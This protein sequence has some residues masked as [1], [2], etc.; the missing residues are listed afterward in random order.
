MV[1]PQKGSTV[2]EPAK[3]LRLFEAGA[4][5]RH[6]LLLR[7]CQAAAERAPAELV[8]GLPAHVLDEIREWVVRQPTSPDEC[9]VIRSVCAGPGFDAERHFREE[10]RQLYDG[11]WR[12]HRYFAEAEPAAASDRC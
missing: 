7:L 9:R 10:A 8:A 12:W 4:I 11:L 6:E 5:T 3:L 2:Y 1:R